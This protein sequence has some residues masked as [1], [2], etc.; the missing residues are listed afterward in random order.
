M[1]LG[2]NNEFVKGNALV[3][4]A[5]TV[6]TRLRSAHRPGATNGRPYGMAENGRWRYPNTCSTAAFT[7]AKIG[8]LYAAPA[9]SLLAP[10]RSSTRL[11]LPE[12]VFGR[13]SR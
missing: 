1:Y 9:A 6:S 7:A 13:A 2:D 4:P 12:I 3:G 5:D 11:I 8:A 10:S